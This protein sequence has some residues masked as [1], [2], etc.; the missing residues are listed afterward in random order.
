MAVRRVL[1]AALGVV[2]V[3]TVTGAACLFPAP[4]ALWAQPAASTAP[5]A[6]VVAAARRSIVT[7]L[8]I[9]SGGGARRVPHSLASGIVYDARGYV[10]TVASAVRDCDAIHVRLADGR[11]V[12]ATLVGADDD[13]DIAVLK[14]SVTGLS[15]LPFAAPGG[16]VSGQG[17]AALAARAGSQPSMTRG[18]VRRRYEEPLGSLL[19]LSNE[20]Y[21]GFSGGPVINGRGELVGLVVGRLAE[22]PADWADAPVAGG[23]ASFALAGDDLKTI[24]SHIE[25]YGH[26]R[27]GFLGVRM[28][29]G[30]V[31]D[32]NRP[33]D[34]FRI[35]VRVED[36]LAGSPAAQIDLRPGD[37]I[38][39]WNG[40]T[41]QSPEDLMRR[42]EG[43]PPGTIVPLVWVR[44][45]ERREGRLIVGTKP[46]EDLVAA[47]RIPASAPDTTRASRPGG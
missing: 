14:L 46:D 23:A 41:L 32:A 19:L 4:P 29:Q 15:P 34:P 20:V 6:S 38:V 17:V 25:Q 31:V 28:V 36:V 10:A 12:K 47:P 18:E 3:T 2:V 1:R 45:E 22:V 27:R 42:V 21:P 8:G 9:R 7:V 13:S 44:N 39:G 43:S 33:D 24:V 5:D 40:E 26:V 30:E 11:E 16:D 35:G 37:L